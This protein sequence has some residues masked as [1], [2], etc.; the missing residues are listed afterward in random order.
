M[1]SGKVTKE[2]SVSLPEI[3]TMTWSALPNAKKTLTMLRTPK[4]KS[5]R[6]CAISLVARLMIS[7]ADIFR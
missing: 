1:S 6:T 4:P 5:I 7:P 3:R 2:A